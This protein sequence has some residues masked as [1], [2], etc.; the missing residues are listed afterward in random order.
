MALLLD[1]LTHSPTVAIW[2]KLQRLYPNEVSMGN[3]DFVAYRL[4]HGDEQVLFSLRY[5][6]TKT[7]ST[8]L[9]ALDWETLPV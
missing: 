9:P 6:P 5:S 2:P 8:L 3:W 1:P 7:K 4:A